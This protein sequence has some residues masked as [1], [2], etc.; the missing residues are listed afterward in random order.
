M[1]SALDLKGK[2]FGDLHAIERYENDDA[3]R[4]QWVCICDCGGAHIA[5][6]SYLVEGRTTR[7]STCVR[8]DG[9][10]IIVWHHLSIHRYADGGFADGCAGFCEALRNGSR[11]IEPLWID[12]VRRKRHSPPMLLDTLRRLAAAGYVKTKTDTASLTS[13]AKRN[14]HKI[15]WH[16]HNEGD[17][18]WA[19]WHQLTGE[20]RGPADRKPQ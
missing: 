6:G 19:A 14:D 16:I 9:I 13:W 1:A 20:W 15:E 18:V 5:R 4:S 2:K 10:R 3:G 17:A 11:V 7:C 12:K 8:A